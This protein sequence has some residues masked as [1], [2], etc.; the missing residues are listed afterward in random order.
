MPSFGVQAEQVALPRGAF[1]KPPRTYVTWDGRPV[2]GLSQND[3]RAYLYPVCTPA[4][5]PVTS[6]SPTDHPHHNSVWV[7]ADHVTA[8]LPFGEDRVEEANYSFYIN[9]TFQGRAAGHIVARSLDPQTVTDD[10]LQLVQTLDWMGPVEWGAPE[11]RTIGQETRTTSIRHV[12]GHAEDQSAF[13]IDVTCEL[14]SAAWPLRIGP[15]RHAWFGIRL[16]EPLRPALGGQ[17]ADATGPQTVAGI[18]GQPG[19]WIQASAEVVSGHTAG[20]VVARDPDTSRL[21]WSL[22]EWGTIDVNPLGTVAQDLADGDTLTCRLRL[23][24]HDGPYTPEQIDH[25]VRL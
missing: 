18:V 23:V 12:A 11:G 5:V 13:L 15:T 6:E 20:L 25:L 17:L 22:Y 8:L 10:H 21:P 16:A 19:P 7:G 14:T 4:G 3:H 2:L 1:H 9:Q 24:V